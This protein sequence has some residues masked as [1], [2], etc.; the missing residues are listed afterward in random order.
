MSNP[1]TA[2]ARQERSH[3][4]GVAQE[5]TLRV[6]RA[7]SVPDYLGPLIQAE[8]EAARAASARDTLD[9]VVAVLEATAAGYKKSGKEEVAEALQ[10]TAASFRAK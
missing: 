1:E 10:L 7:I 8:R 3:C 4:D 6:L 5:V 9:R 2:E